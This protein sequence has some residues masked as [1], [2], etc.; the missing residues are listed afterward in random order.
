MAAWA[1]TCRETSISASLSSPSHL[2]GV[3]IDLSGC[4]VFGAEKNPGM[5]LPLSETVTL[6]FMVI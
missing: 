3:G 4:G 6:D 1:P 5:T 2:A